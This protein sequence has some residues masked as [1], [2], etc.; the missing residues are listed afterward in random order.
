[1]KHRQII[2]RL[3]DGSIQFNNPFSGTESWYTPGRRHRPFHTEKRRHGISLDKKRCDDYCD[4]CPANYEKT[5][6]EKSR[7]EQQSGKMVLLHEPT[8][9]HVFSTTAEVRRIGNLYEIIPWQY[10]K[11]NYGAELSPKQKAHQQAY[12]DSARGRAHIHS[13]LEIKRRLISKHRTDKSFDNSSLFEMSEAFFGGAH[14]LII[15]RRHFIDDAKHSHQLCATGSLSPQE[16]YDYFRLTLYAVQDIH[17]NNPFVKFVCV[18]T[19]WLR[20]AG[21]SFEHL[22]RQVLGFDRFGNTIEN[23]MSLA[24]ENP[25]IFQDY[26]DYIAGDQRLVLAQNQGTISFVDVGHPFS[27]I[28]IFAQN[29]GIDPLAVL[30]ESHRH[31]SDMVHAVHSCFAPQDAVNEEWYYKPR[32]VEVE[33][34]WFILIKW[35]NHRH[36]GIESIANLYPDDY[37]PF[38][39]RDQ[40]VTKLKRLKREGK[41]AEMRVGDDCV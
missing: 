35:R 23:C 33:I 37:N 11:M 25:I 9:D 40:L 31:M 18:Y 3:K 5:T 28:S 20:D 19:N 16:H 13:V 7:I 17:A 26:V 2:T 39:L 22:H 1:M 21:A 4:F 34:P 36:A 24:K 29:N 27:T 41:I 15:P 30:S 6:P 12:M 10:W 38:A 14:E 32:A 8:T